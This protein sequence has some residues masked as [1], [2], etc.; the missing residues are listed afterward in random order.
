MVTE[1]THKQQES[2]NKYYFK[3]HNDCNKNDVREAIIYLYKVT[4]L[5]LN[6]VNV[7]SK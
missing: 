1:K 4:P 3:V 7:V 2:V 5:K 6:I